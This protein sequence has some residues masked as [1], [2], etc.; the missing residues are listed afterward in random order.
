MRWVR[1]S[2]ALHRLQHHLQTGTAMD[3][4]HI[5]SI[6]TLLADLSARTEQLRGYL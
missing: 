2:P 5:N 3:V 1:E 6:G 4:E